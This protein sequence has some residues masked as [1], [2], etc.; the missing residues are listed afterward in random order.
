MKNLTV[1]DYQR[2]YTPTALEQML[3]LAGREAD[4]KDVQR[5]V[6]KI[7]EALKNLPL[8][9]TP[10]QNRYDHSRWPDPGVDYKENT[11]QFLPRAGYS[12]NREDYPAN[13][14]E[15]QNG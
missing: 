3:H 13:P 11:V 1:E 12:Q 7:Q 14:W 6:V 5:E 15:S 10:Y 9:P 8:D 4:D 2:M